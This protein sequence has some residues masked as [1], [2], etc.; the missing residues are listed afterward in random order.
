MKFHS[1]KALFVDEL[2][3]I[4]G[5]DEALA[6]FQLAF[7]QLTGRSRSQFL[8]VQDQETD[9]SLISNFNTVL[10]GLQRQQPI[11][12]VL[13]TAY[14]YGQTFRVNSSVLIPRPETEELVYWIITT[15]KAS[16]FT[17]ADLLDIGT[18]SGCIAISLK[19]HLP[20]SKVTALDTSSQALEITQLNAIDNNAEINTIHAD[21]LHYK[22]DQQ[23]DIIVSNP[24]YVREL[25]KADMQSQVLDHEPHLALF[26]S[27]DDPLI[28]Y[29][30]IA[31]FALLSLRENG[32]LFFEINEYLGAETVA[33]LHLKGFNR[34]ELRKDMQGK[35]RMIL[36]ARS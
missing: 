11:Q 20:E 7:E 16:H 8:L 30:S 13:G 27:N 3:K 12:Y 4:Y 26:V 2:S 34:V 22:S 9:E 6:L 36:A 29:Q 1:V 21:I 24:P 33:M 14:F 32:L 18:G 23:Y 10:T 17:K 19:T 5:T 15:C 35:D 25:E 28:F 31:D